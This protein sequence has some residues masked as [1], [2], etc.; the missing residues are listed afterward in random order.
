MNVRVL[1]CDDQAPFRTAAHMVVE[2]TEGFDMI[3]EADTGEGAVELAHQLCPDLV[4]MDVNLPGI[5]GLEATRQVLVGSA[6]TVV[7]GSADGDG[8]FRRT[9]PA[10]KL[11]GVHS[12]RGPTR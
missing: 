8:P 6:G 7:V 11:T 2:M 9:G 12:G 4:L 1:I 5:D 10:V 3:G